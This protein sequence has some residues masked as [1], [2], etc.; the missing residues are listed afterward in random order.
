VHR[1]TC[2]PPGPDDRHGAGHDEQ[3]RQRHDRQR[4][5]RTSVCNT[6]RTLPDRELT[7]ALAGESA[8]AALAA[9]AAPGLD[10]ERASRWIIRISSRAPLSFTPHGFTLARGLAGGTRHL[11]GA[12]HSRSSWA[13]GAAGL[14]RRHVST[15]PGSVTQLFGVHIFARL[16]IV[17]AHWMSVGPP[18]HAR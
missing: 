11:R 18:W 6:S 3:D 1:A 12:V 14:P 2:E 15:A 7:S 13:A 9:A 8:S 16:F 17:P 5:A 10:H 4:A